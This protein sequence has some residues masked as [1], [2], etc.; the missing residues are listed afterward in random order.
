MSSGHFIVIGD[1]DE[2]HGIVFSTLTLTYQ[3]NIILQI[4][5]PSYFELMRIDLHCLHMRRL[6]SNPEK[7]K[8]NKTHTFLTHK[9][10]NNRL[11]NDLF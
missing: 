5:I 2:R 7:T 3:S 1:G 10:I 8:K 9:N 4:E 6:C 11:L